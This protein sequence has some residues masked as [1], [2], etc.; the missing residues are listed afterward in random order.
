LI[1]VCSESVAFLLSFYGLDLCAFHEEMVVGPV[2]SVGWV[3][4]FAK[5]KK[6][7]KT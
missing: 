6:E 4:D 7:K 2:G 3:W 1:V 5:K